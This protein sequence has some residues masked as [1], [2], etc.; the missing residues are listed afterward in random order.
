MERGM[1]PV[2]LALAFGG[3]GGQTHGQ[4][5]PAAPGGIVVRSADFAPG[6]PIPARDTCVAGGGR[7]ALTWSHVPAGAREL[8]VLVTDRDAGDFVHWSVYGLA[9]GSGGAGR[10]PA[11]GLPHGA[12]EGANSFGRDGWGAPCPPKG[13]PPHHYVFTVYWLRRR[14]GLRAGAEPRD[15]AVTISATAGGRG[16][17]VGRFARAG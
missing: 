4:A 9:P 6:G 5:P 11:T 2:A 14:S 8:A 15:V 7:P 10:L 12:R 13:D 16:E 17:L 3:C 1:M